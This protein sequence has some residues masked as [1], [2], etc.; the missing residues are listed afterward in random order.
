MRWHQCLLFHISG[1]SL[2]SRI[3][4]VHTDFDGTEGDHGT[5][6]F[7]DGTIDLLQIVRVG[8]D[9]VTGDNI[10]YRR[11]MLAL[12]IVPFAV[13]GEDRSRHSEVGSLLAVSNDN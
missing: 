1:R 4:L 10:L 12:C 8:D 7:V 13:S 6:D 3:R 11:T 2:S 9:L 5:V